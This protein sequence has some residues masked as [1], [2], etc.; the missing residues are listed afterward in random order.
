MK[1]AIFTLDGYFNYGNILQRYALQYFLCGTGGQVDS[2]WH[3]SENF[4]P[5][6]WWQWEWKD[7]VKFLLNYKGVRSQILSNY[8]G[9]EM[10]RQGK[11]KDWC[12]RYIN[13]RKA[14]TDLRELVHEYDYFIVGSDQVWNPHFSDLKHCFLFFAPPE[15]RIAYAAS[16]SCPEI[17]KEKL[18]LYQK[19]LAEM[20]FISMRE[21]QGADMVKDISDRDVPVVVDPTLLLSPDDWRKVNRQPAWY[22]GEKYILTYFLG[23]RPK[24]INSLEQKTGLKVV[25]LLDT[26]IYEHYVTGPDELLWAIEHAK[27]VYTD[28]FHGT[29]FSILFHTPFVV[30]DRVGDR[31]TEGMGARFDTLLGFLGLEARRGTKE[32]DYV[33]EN[34]LTEPDWSKVDE[35]LEMERNRSKDYICK[36]MEIV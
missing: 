4:M 26:E 8:H 25:N 18:A 24:I 5:K 33:I 20:A 12:D 14:P 15:K 28:S 36:A 23:K 2:V 34:P 1:I 10:V 30:C 21:Q 7:Q 27:L 35:M 6:M 29:V 17:P 3:S 16:I 9:M 32:N 22:H 19:G 31:V 13:I 11:I